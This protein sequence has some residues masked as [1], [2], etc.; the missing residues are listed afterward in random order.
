MDSRCIGNAG[1]RARSEVDSSGIVFE[2]E[3]FNVE[4]QH[5]D[6][7]KVLQ[8]K[9]YYRINTPDGVIVLALTPDNKIVLVEQFRPALGRRTLELPAGTIDPGETPEEA[10][11][12]ELYEETGFICQRLT[13]LKNGQ[14][15]SSRLNAR[16]FSFVGVG[17]VQ[18]VSYVSKEDIKVLL[19][20]PY[21]LKQLVLSDHFSQYAGLALLVLA[22]WKSATFFT[23]PEV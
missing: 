22:D 12:R 11:A 10:V 23:R 1:P 2:T 6:N 3:W 8:G 4:R 20:S 19:V 17:A 15:M 7:I 21:E 18:Q 14:L 13:H 5:Y 16:L 9:P